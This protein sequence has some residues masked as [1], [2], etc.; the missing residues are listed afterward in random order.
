[1]AVSSNAIATLVKMME[2]LPESAQ[3]RAVDQMRAYLED[4]QDEMRWDELF[5]RSQGNLVA[6]AKRA[7][8]QIADG[9]AKPMDFERL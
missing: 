2:T 6:A 4:L 3:E 7:R 5:E 8:K 9:L 1:M